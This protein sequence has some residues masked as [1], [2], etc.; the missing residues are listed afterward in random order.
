MYKFK[1]SEQI[2]INLNSYVQIEY[3][4]YLRKKK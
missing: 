1:K 4:E 3:I 2:L